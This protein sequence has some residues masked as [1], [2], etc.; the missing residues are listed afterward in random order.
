MNLLRQTQK[1]AWSLTVLELGGEDA[2]GC[3]EVG[4]GDLAEV[5]GDCCEEDF[6]EGYAGGMLVGRAHERGGLFGK[7]NSRIRILSL[8]EDVDVYGQFGRWCDSRRGNSGGGGW[9]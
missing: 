6:G 1:P 4:G 8:R 7:G 5:G 2:G 3:R 9:L